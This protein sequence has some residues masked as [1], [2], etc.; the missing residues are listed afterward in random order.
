MNNTAFRHWSVPYS[1]MEREMES[2]SSVRGFGGRKLH[3]NESHF[4]VQ[5]EKDDCYTSL[6]FEVKSIAGTAINLTGEDTM[7]WAGNR[8]DTFM[9]Y[10]GN[11]RGNFTINW[12]ASVKEEPVFVPTPKRSMRNF[13]MRI[14]SWFSRLFRI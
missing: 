14:F 7:I 5:T 3:G 10:H 11:D 2:V 12:N 1:A 4:W 13:M 6:Y 9:G 8:N